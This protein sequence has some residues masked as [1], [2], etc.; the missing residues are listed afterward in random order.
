MKRLLILAC[1]LT[2]AAVQADDRIDIQ[3]LLGFTSGQM[4]SLDTWYANHAGPDADVVEDILGTIKARADG[5]R[6]Q[7][8]QKYGTDVSAQRRMIQLEVA[9]EAEQA[10]TA[11]AEATK[12]SALADAQDAQR[13]EML[14]AQAKSDSLTAVIIAEEDVVRTLRVAIQA[15]RDSVEAARPIDGDPV[16]GVSP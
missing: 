3:S 4:D 12:A 15:L 16:D 7:Y 5:L 2:V 13:V 14:A 10:A 9:I 8:V 11:A 1:L 6:E